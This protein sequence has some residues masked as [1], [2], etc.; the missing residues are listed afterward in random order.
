MTNAIEIQRLGYRTGR[1]F[2]RFD[3]GLQLNQVT[4]DEAGRQAQVPQ[5][6]DQ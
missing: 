3:V 5:G 6:L 4:G 1:T 2:E